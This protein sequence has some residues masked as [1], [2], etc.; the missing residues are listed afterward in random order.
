MGVTMVFL[1]L[2]NIL[3]ILQLNHQK[4]HYTPLKKKYL[5][6]KITAYYLSLDLFTHK[7]PSKLFLNEKK[8]ISVLVVN[9]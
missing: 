7:Q 4:K 2:K 1:H 6:I 8:N 9:F 3:A 5:L